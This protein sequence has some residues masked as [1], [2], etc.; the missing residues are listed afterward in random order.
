MSTHGPHITPATITLIG[1][2]GTE[3]GIATLP[4]GYVDPQPELPPAR[5]TCP[6]GC[7][8]WRAVESGAAVIPRLNRTELLDWLNA[9]AGPP[10]SSLA[11]NRMYHHMRSTQPESPLNVGFV[12]V[13]RGLAAF[14]LTPMHYRAVHTAA[15]SLSGERMLEALGGAVAAAATGINFT[16][17]NGLLPTPA[18]RWRQFC[19]LVWHAGSAASR[20]LLGE[21]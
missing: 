2:D 14:D 7:G 1:D 19:P 18:L 4:R 3:Y 6:A 10:R 15:R 21:Q 5:L 8:C 12:G 16:T 20:R 17:R 11:H 13:A 9:L